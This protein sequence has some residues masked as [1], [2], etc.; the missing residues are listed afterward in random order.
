MLIID[1]YIRLSYVPVD[2]PPS[3]L[4]LLL[5]CFRLLNWTVFVVLSTCISLIK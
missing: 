5:V 4:S 2:I 3:P 1:T